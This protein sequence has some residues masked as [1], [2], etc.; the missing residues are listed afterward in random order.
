MRLAIPSHECAH[1][2]VPLALYNFQDTLRTRLRAVDALLHSDIAISAQ[3]GRHVARAIRPDLCSNVLEL[4]VLVS[5][6][7]VEGSLAHTVARVLYDGLGVIEVGLQCDTT[8]AGRNVDDSG[9]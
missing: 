2:G 1:L 6:E 7:H 9:V 5:G 4:V 3:V 8:E